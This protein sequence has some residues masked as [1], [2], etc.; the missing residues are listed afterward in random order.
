MNLA[1]TGFNLSRLHRKKIEIRVFLM[2]DYLGGVLLK[3]LLVQLY[4]LVWD[5]RLYFLYLQ[6]PADDGVF[7]NNSKKLV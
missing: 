7:L 6:F 4:G 1:E 3:L 2:V 5:H